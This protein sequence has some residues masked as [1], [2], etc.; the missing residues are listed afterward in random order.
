MPS[1]R[2]KLRT[3]HVSGIMEN[4]ILRLS[5]E[6]RDNLCAY[7]DGELDEGLAQDIEKI[8]TNNPVARNDVEML[9]RTWELLDEL[10][11]PGAS[12]QFTEKTLTSIKT[13]DVREPITEKKWF[14]KARRGAIAAGWAAAVAASGL[15]GFFLTHN[16][17]P[18]D[19]RVL[20]HELP[21]IENIDVYAEVDNIEFLREL[22]RS[23][24]FNAGAARP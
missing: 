11:R 2:P 15:L 8:L 23:G 21:L 1:E 4:K 18:S 12:Q 6:Q 5:A 24:L 9:T 10:P 3:V 14:D 13:M 17:V 7:L 16:L 20:I 19:A 22:N